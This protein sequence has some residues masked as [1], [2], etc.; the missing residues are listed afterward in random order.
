MAEDQEVANRIW[1][2]VLIEDV[3]DDLLDA[4]NDNFD[5]DYFED[6]YPY[7]FFLMIGMGIITNTL[8]LKKATI[9]LLRCLFF[10]SHL[11]IDWWTWTLLGA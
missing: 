2:V 10:K 11:T 9:R 5:P 1:G 3:E 6:S 7:K 8:Q 4:I